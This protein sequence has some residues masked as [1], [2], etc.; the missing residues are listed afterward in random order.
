MSDNQKYD[1][2]NISRFSVNEKE[3]LKIAAFKLNCQPSN[4]FSLTDENK[5]HLSRFS[6]KGS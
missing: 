5:S 3:N 4:P 6:Q 2:E 1:V